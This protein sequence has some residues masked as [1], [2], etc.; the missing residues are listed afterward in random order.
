M[1]LNLVIITGTCRTRKRKH[2]FNTGCIESMR[3][4]TFWTDY[5]TRGFKSGLRVLFAQANF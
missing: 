1:K 3:M 5:Y 2:V 4:Q